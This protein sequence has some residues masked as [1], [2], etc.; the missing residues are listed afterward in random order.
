MVGAL[1]AR[2]RIAGIGLLL[3]GA[4]LASVLNGCGTTEEET[5]APPIVPAGE[6]DPAVWGAEFPE[7]YGT[8]LATAEPRPAG[9]SKYKRG[10]DSGEMF[11]KLSEYPFMPLLFNGWGFGI[12]Y[13]EPRGH[14]YMLIDQSEVDPARVKAG[15]AC[16]TCKSSYTQDLYQEDKDA[17]FDATYDEAVALREHV[18]AVHPEL[19]VVLVGPVEGARPW[20]KN[21]RRREGP[22]VLARARHRWRPHLRSPLVAPNHPHDRGGADAARLAHL[23]QH[24]RPPP[25]RLPQRF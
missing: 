19:D 20:K 14:Y 3:A 17:L 22:R 23:T 12:D 11:D 9:L 8:W 21:A 7:E 5:A 4:L 1:S 18:T 6:H 10:F 2:A 24:R 16:L 15:G 25:A 13:N